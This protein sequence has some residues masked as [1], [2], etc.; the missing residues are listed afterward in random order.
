MHLAGQIPSPRG[1]IKSSVS[2]MVRLDGFRG[3]FQTKGFYDAANS[4]ALGSLCTW[5]PRK[6]CSSSD[7]PL[8]VTEID[9]AVPSSEHS[10]VFFLSG[11]KYLV[12]I[13]VFTFLGVQFPCFCL[14]E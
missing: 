10:A 6:D 11:L 14:L 3:L 5:S 7:T 8:S 1:L 12:Q 9:F 13:F 4:A 2:L